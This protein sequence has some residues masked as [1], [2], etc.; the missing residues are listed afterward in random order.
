M[1]RWEHSAQNAVLFHDVG[2][3]ATLRARPLTQ[4]GGARKSSPVFGVR[5]SVSPWGGGVV[6][7]QA[8]LGETPGSSINKTGRAHGNRHREVVQ[9]REG[10]RL[11]Y[12]RGR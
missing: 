12:A 5:L 11:H 4:P 8:W 6:E 2:A 9:R 1:R 7:V 3:H 10:L